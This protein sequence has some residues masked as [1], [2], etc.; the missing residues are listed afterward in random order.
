MLLTQYWSL[1]LS[2]IISLIGLALVIVKY[3]KNKDKS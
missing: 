3:Y 1:Y 2:S